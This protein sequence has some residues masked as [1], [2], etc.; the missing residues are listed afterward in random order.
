MLGPDRAP[1]VCFGAP[2]F[3]GRNWPAALGL[4]PLQCFAELP[5]W[6]R[7]PVPLRFPPVPSLLPLR[8]HD[9]SVGAA[10][11]GFT[12][13]PGAMPYTCAIGNR[14][15]DP[16]VVDPWARPD[17][18]SQSGCS[19]AILRYNAIR[20]LD[21]VSS[22]TGRGR[23]GVRLAFALGDGRRSNRRRS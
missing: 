21:G 4:L 12:A 11:P 7:L 5:F 10:A 23:A 2:V 9:R 15:Q 14:Q 13:S 19:P 6:C 3:G 18:S 22:S 17:S 1:E 16:P 8:C 20:A